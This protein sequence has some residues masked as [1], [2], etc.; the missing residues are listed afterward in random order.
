MK[1]NDHI[2]GHAYAL[3]FAALAIITALLLPAPLVGGALA[4][5]VVSGAT[6]TFDLEEGMKIL[7]TDTLEDE[8]IK[9]TEFLDLI[10]TDTGGIKTETTTGGRYIE[11]AKMFG[12]PAGFGFRTE[13]DPI[14]HALPP[15]ILNTRINLKKCMGTVSL[16]GDVFERVTGD[17]GAFTDW[18]EQQFPSLEERIRNEKDRI[19]LGYGSGVKA[20]VAAID[21]GNKIV[22]VKDAMGLGG[23]GLAGLQ[24]LANE[25]ICFAA[26]SDGSTL[27]L[28]AAGGHAI[29]AKNVDTI[30]SQVYCD[31]LPTGLAVDDYIFS[32]DES[33]YSFLDSATG[34][35]RETMG[36]MGHVDDGGII[37]NYF[38]IPRTGASGKHEWRSAVVDISGA[39][40]SGTFN[41]KA[42]IYGDRMGNVHGGAN[43]THILAPYSG[44]EA[45]WSWLATDRSFNDGRSMVGGMEKEQK[46]RLRGRLVGIRSARKIPP[47]IAFGITP[48]TFKRFTTGK[49]EWVKRHG[50][51]WHLVQTG[52]ARYDASWAYCT[53]W[54]E[55]FCKSPRQNIRWEGLD[56]TK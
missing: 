48:S 17:R 49:Y 40:Y 51:I 53:E 14:P 13:A 47:Q 27:R 30:N 42:I 8:T 26:G 33:G 1:L 11:G 41:E 20:R 18:A 19:A 9:D 38:N 29:H 44:A 37:A 45:F 15:E 43:I 50:S 56:P 39:P 31:Q 34:R 12:L 35:L 10:E 36:M 28:R 32:C 46:I 16:T 5:G 52:N 4:P 25:N 7:F 21:A 2:T 23:F 24:F 6:D 3:M 54:E 22:T 55:M